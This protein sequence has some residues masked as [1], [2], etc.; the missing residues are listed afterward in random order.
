MLFKR[1]LEMI[2]DKVVL[3]D[4]PI[5][6]GGHDY[7]ISNEWAPRERVHVENIR[8]TDDFVSL[9]TSENQV[10]RQHSHTFVSSQSSELRCETGH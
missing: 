2:L 10:N 3:L 7:I 1:N 8:L 4:M 5:F 9:K 6:S